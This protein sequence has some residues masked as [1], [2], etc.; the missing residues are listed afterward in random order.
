[1]PAAPA[2]APLDAAIERVCMAIDLPA[3]AGRRIA[4]IAHDNSKQF[5]HGTGVKGGCL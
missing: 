2:L 4:L 3:P 1:M 5:W